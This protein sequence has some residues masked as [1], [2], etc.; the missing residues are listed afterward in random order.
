MLLGDKKV[1]RKFIRKSHRFD[2]D[3]WHDPTMKTLPYDSKET[4]EHAALVQKL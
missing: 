4:V 1:V 2:E 3:T